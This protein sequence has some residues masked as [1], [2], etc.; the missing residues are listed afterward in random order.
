MTTERQTI[1][2]EC[3]N[4]DV[5]TADVACRLTVTFTGSTFTGSAFNVPPRYSLYSI[6][7]AV[8]AASAEKNVLFLKSS[9]VAS[10]LP[11]T[12][13]TILHYHSVAFPPINEFSEIDRSAPPAL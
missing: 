9:I 13:P 11:Q 4:P 5:G 3:S 1:T 7:L 8:N 12:H 6:S 2:N 10:R